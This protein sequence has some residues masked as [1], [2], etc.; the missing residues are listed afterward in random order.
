MIKIL[1]IGLTSYVGLSLANYTKG[2]GS[3]YLVELTSSRNDS[4]K[5]KD[6]SQYDVIC[7]PAAIVHRPDAPSELYYKIN[8]DMAIEIAQKAK[9][10]GVKQFIQI[11]TNGV[12]G[13]D[14]GV[15]SEM[16]EYKP[17]NDYGKSK[18]E[19]D[20]ALVTL[21]DDTFK[22]CIIRPPMIYGSGCKGNYN[23]LEKYA[24]TIPIFPSIKNKKDFLFIDNLSDFILFVVKNNLEGCFYPTDPE[25]TCVTEWVKK[26]ARYN[27]KKMLLMDI[28]NPFVKIGIKY[29]RTL[30]LVFADNYSIFVNNTG[31]IAPYSLDEA[32]K[33]MYLVK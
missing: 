21:S 7:N 18:L 20:K 8:R 9:T 14:V 31:W 30:A 11:S 6:F 5:N 19:A 25:T 10:S 4:W 12:F 13:I 22:V 32:L 29:F 26:I 3:D 24:L 27:S 16:S 15:M 2:L 28:F 23:K 1:I 17:Y 33:K